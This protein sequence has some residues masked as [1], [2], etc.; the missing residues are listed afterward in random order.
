MAEHTIDVS[1][2][3]QSPGLN[4]RKVWQWLFRN[5]EIG[6][7]QNLDSFLCDLDIFKSHFSRHKPLW[8]E[9]GSGGYT[10][11]HDFEMPDTYKIEVEYPVIRITYVPH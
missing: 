5:T 1:H 9:L 11:V 2:C 10:F 8:W 3:D 6:K 7:A 4:A